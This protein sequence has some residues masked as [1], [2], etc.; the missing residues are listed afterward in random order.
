MLFGEYLIR[1][2]QSDPFIGLDLYEGDYTLFE[3][4]LEHFQSFGKRLF[5][6]SNDACNV[7]L[8]ERRLNRTALGISK[9]EMA[10]P[11]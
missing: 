8:G 7:D 11:G 3:Q 5:A 9:G 2:L 6:S 1:Q 4:G 10:I